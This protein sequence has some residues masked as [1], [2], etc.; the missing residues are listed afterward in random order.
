MYLLVIICLFLNS[1]FQECY[2]SYNEGMILRSERIDTR[3]TKFMPA[4]KPMKKKDYWYR[5]DRNGDDLGDEANFTDNILRVLI[6][7]L[8]GQFKKNKDDRVETIKEILRS[9]NKFIKDNFIPD[10]HQNSII[11][12]FEHIE[13][14]QHRPI[15]QLKNLVF[16]KLSDQAQKDYRDGVRVQTSDLHRDIR[17][18]NEFEKVDPTK[19]EILF[20]QLI[21]DAEARGGTR[22]ELL[23]RIEKD[24]AKIE[25]IF[26]QDATYKIV[27][28]FNSLRAEIVAYTQNESPLPE[29]IRFIIS[30]ISIE[31]KHNIQ[32]EYKDF[33]EHKDQD[34]WKDITKIKAQS[35]VSMWIK[36]PEIKKPTAAEIAEEQKE[37]K[38]K[39]EKGRFKNEVK[40]AKENGIKNLENAGIEATKKQFSGAI[41]G[42][43]ESLSKMFPFN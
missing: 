21:C 31:N 1:A 19:L 13:K 36:K 32:K 35:P 8:V 5:R 38:E 42:F 15:M 18:M 26:G 14:L 29:V 39:E 11:E 6:E 12:I 41:E 24:M 9:I 34:E 10:D 17:N 27:G 23:Q 37:K 16:D 7:K 33:L 25:R 4:P 3:I 43:K 40:A 30:L 22:Q 28:N 20:M 2:G